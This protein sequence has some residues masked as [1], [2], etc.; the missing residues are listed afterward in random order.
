MSIMKNIGRS[1]LKYSE[2]VVNK[3]D[4]FT[5]IAKLNIEIKKALSEIEDAKT[6]IGNFVAEQHAAGKESVKMN[7]SGISA[8]LLIIN[9][10]KTKIDS[11]KKDLEEIKKKK[12]PPESEKTE[13][14]PG[15]KSANEPETDNK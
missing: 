10:L 6:R 9:E 1:F 4:S 14:K 5:Q 13:E 8:D 2:Q 7:D 11:Y 15:D 12:T 3:T